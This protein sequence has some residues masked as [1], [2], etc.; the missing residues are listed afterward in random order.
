MD[1]LITNAPTD[2]GLGHPAKI[3]RPGIFDLRGMALRYGPL[4]SAL[5]WVAG[6][7]AAQQDSLIAVWRND[8]QP[9]STRMHAAGEALRTLIYQDPDSALRLAMDLY[10]AATG[11]G[12]RR[13]QA[14]ALNFQGMSYVLIGNF[15][16]AVVAYREMLSLYEQ[17]DDRRG[18]AGAH[19]KP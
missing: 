6:P 5:L 12:D 18:V 11:A 3:A 13:R 1:Q 10:G 7:L 15:Y 19:S 17:L 2:G 14:F 4:V 16:P 9:D 8:S